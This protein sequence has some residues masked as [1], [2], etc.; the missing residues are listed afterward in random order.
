MLLRNKVNRDL[1]KA[2]KKHMERGLQDN[3]LSSA[4]LHKGVAKFL[5]WRKAGAPNT[6]LSY[7]M[8]GKGRKL[9]T[10]LNNK[11]RLPRN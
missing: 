4:S 6:L 10:D 8:V 7:K 5:G 9:E 11:I 2:R 3:M 1:K